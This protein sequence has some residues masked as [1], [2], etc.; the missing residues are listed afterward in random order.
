VVLFSGILQFWFLV[1]PSKLERVYAGTVINQFQNLIP[2]SAV[3]Q[4]IVT[5]SADLSLHPRKWV[6]P[7]GF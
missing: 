6:S 2:P 3:F 5:E 7:T 1:P 4:I